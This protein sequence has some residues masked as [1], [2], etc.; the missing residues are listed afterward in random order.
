[1][2][3]ATKTLLHPFETGMLDLPGEGRVLV[4]NASEAVLRGL[5]ADRIDAVQDFRPE[6]LKL[7]RTGCKATPAPDGTGYAMALVLCGRHRQINEHNVGE[8]NARVVPG[9]L[10]VVAGLKTDGAESLRKRLG[11]RFALEGQAAKHHGNVFWFKADGTAVAPLEPVL[12]DGRFENVPGLFS[13]DRIDPGSQ[14]LVRNL[15]KEVFGAVAD[16]GAGWGYLAAEI[17]AH[18]PKV[19]RIDLYEASHAAAKAGE[20]NMARLAGTVQT[21]TRWLDVI[22]EDPRERFDAAVMNPPFH[23]ARS[24]DPDIGRAMI[25]AAWRLLKPGGR[26]WLVANVHL[27]YEAVLSEQ[28]SASGMIAR[29]NGFKVLWARK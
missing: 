16:V 20:A 9:G 12:V 29:E 6:F 18:R 26:L 14:I 17:A 27:S 25:A 7:E 13:H 3:D 10:V 2:T 8:A 22:A 23:T 19:K 28:F 5:K 24:G 1:M 21:T 11:D 15:P 4:L